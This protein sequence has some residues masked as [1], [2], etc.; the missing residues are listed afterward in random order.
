[1]TQHRL[2]TWPEPFQAIWDGIKAFEL[3]KDDRLFV[4]GD[5]LRLIE[6]VPGAAGHVAYPTK[7]TILCDVNYMIRNSGPFPGI[8]AGY[9]LMGIRVRR[10]NKG[11]QVSI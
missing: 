6:W 4:I 1:M 5:E 3:R 8:E 11:E 10:R 2:K 7:R 9:V